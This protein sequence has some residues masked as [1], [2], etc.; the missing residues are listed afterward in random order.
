MSI[1][2]VSVQDIIRPEFIE[3]HHA[4]QGDVTLKLADGPV[5]LPMRIVLFNAMLLPIY[6]TFR[7]KITKNEL[8]WPDRTVD[9]E[10]GK[11]IY[12][13]TSE[14]VTRCTNKAYNEL[15][16]K[17]GVENYMDAVAQVW[18]AI[19]RIAMFADKYTRE[20]QVSLDA[21][22][23]A[24][25]CA[26][27]PMKEIIE[28][29]ID[30][31]HGIKYAEQQFEK[32]SKE[33][34][35]VLGRPGLLKDNVLMP[36]MLTKL[37]K[38]NQVPQMFY[39]FGPRSDITDEMMKHVVSSSAWSGLRG[40]EDFATE[41]LSAK[42]AEYFNSAVIQD[43]QYFARR[44]RL[45][46]SSMPRLYKG[47]CG[48]KVTIP[49]V[50]PAKN[51][52]NYLGKFVKVDDSTKDLLKTRKWKPQCGEDYSV[53]LTEENIDRFV[54]REIQ[55]WSPFGCRHTD[56]CCEHCAGTMHQR[57]GAYIPDGIH[58]GVFSTTK[59][60]SA[61]TQK[62]LSAKHLIKTSS[63]E[64]LLNPRASKYLAK[65]GDAI[66]WN[67]GVAKGISKCKMRLASECLLGP[68]NDLTRKLLPAGVSFS[69]ID[70]MAIVNPKGD[71]IDMI[72]V[73]DGTTVPFF[74]AYAMLYMQKHYKEIEVDS[75]YI[76]IPMHSFDFEKPLLKYTAVNDDMV[77][78]VKRV[79][80]FVTGEVSEYTSISSA[81]HDFSELIYDKTDVNIFPIEIMLRSYLVSENS[82]S[83]PVI[84]DPYQPVKF[85]GMSDV[86][87]GA[88]LSTKLAYQ[89]VNDFFRDPSPTLDAIGD[90][91]AYNDTLFR[92]STVDS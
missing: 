56:G 46:A 51:K 86:I 83:T 88:A 29:E 26:Q 89:G 7:I 20:Y 5:V 52:F 53:E 67:S 43:A 73:S 72:E 27:K 44:C 61:V 48:S 37:L 23:L 11:A 85:A 50:I 34:M 12:S 3:Q 47:S 18:K 32:T 25:L 82:M 76:D 2:T 31:S 33:L 70:K 91:Y 35:K 90:G 66:L 57:L 75:D 41:S 65:S 40:I 6:T 22:S 13:F 87:S 74:S 42:K 71:V 55:M 79:E 38:R 77:S 16:L 80:A 17:Y 14:T 9:K 84:T 10:T 24:K 36:F 30:T 8:F 59:A 78:Y 64:F 54:E 62:I 15:I 19:N 81:L 58:L 45:A 92:F 63:K 4:T 1:M 68:M 69:R 60:V 28:R 21:L 39:A 49:Y